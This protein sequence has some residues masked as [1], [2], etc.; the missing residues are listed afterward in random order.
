MS[1]YQMKPW[2][3]MS[4][5]SKGGLTKKHGRKKWGPRH[6][7]AAN[8]TK[9]YR[10]SN[11]R[12]G[13]HGSN[14]SSL[15]INN[16]RQVPRRFYNSGEDLNRS[17]VVA[18]RSLNSYPL[19]ALDRISQI[20]GNRTRRHQQNGYGHNRY[21]PATVST[22]SHTEYEHGH[23]AY[24]PPLYAAVSN[25]LRGP[26]M[27]E[28]WQPQGCGVLDHN[29]GST[30]YFATPPTDHRFPS[31]NPATYQW[32][33]ASPRCTRQWEAQAAYQSSS[34]QDSEQANALG[35][36][37]YD[38]EPLRQ[39][40]KKA[41]ARHATIEALKADF[42]EVMKEWNRDRQKCDFEIFAGELAYDPEHA[43]Y[44]H[45]TLYRAYDP[46]AVSVS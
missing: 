21:N 6:G 38:A 2:K 12:Q 20:G 40:L 3:K 34:N 14:R 8:N 42:R 44:E 24:V 11:F 15:Y 5:T 10:P 45:D 23:S 22:Q 9:K 28:K 39:A 35:L 1:L 18:S 46:T 26:E 37:P 32:H 19:A 30:R 43:G 31:H 29:R 7:G 25:Q 4:S 17:S 36:Q 41:I 27:N 33:G 16:K 13:E